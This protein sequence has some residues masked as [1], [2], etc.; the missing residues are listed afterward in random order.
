MTKLLDS[1]CQTIS[2]SFGLIKKIEINSVELDI[3]DHVKTIVEL[4]TK[5]KSSS[6]TTPGTLRLPFKCE[7]ATAKILCRIPFVTLQK[8]CF[9]A[10]LMF[11]G[12]CAGTLTTKYSSVTLK[13]DVLTFA[14]FD[15]VLEVTLEE[16]QHCAHLVLTSYSQSSVSIT[17]DGSG[18][19]VANFGRIF[20]VHTISKLS[21]VATSCLRGSSHFSGMRC[22]DLEPTPENDISRQEFV[23]ASMDLD[24]SLVISAKVTFSNQGQLLI[25]IGRLEFDI[26]VLQDGGEEQ[27]IGVLVHKDLKIGQGDNVSSV[28]LYFDM[29][30]EA[31]RI[32]LTNLTQGDQQ[33]DYQGFS[34]SS[35]HPLIAL[36]AQKMRS[37]ITFCQFD[38]GL[39]ES[40]A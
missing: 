2:H 20:G 8:F 11:E 27:R 9:M 24:T 19:V 33:A 15:A 31:T 39:L 29:K 25:L 14:D 3:R 18:S 12:K 28:M 22:S 1:L 7:K 5:E 34:E 4:N 38:Y 6:T 37:N 36:A 32:F 40:L 16:M 10:K 35:K 17:F 23:P 30:L 26:I 13:G 21:L